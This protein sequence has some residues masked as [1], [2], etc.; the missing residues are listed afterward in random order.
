MSSGFEDKQWDAIVIGTGVGGGTVGRALAEKGLSVLF[1]EKGGKGLRT[2]QTALNAE[3]TDRVARQVRGFWPDPIEGRINGRV[4]R[5]F[6][7]LGAGVGGSSVYYAATLERPEPHDLD[8]SP[9]HPHPAGGWPVQYAQFHPYIEAAERMYHICGS[10]DPLSSVQADNL[11]PAPDLPPGDAALMAQMQRVGLHPYRLHS[12]VRYLDG[13]LECLGVKCPR[14]CKM[15]GRSAGVEPALATGRATLLE[16]CEVIALRGEPG[17][18]TH[19]EALHDGQP[20][21]LRG[22]IVVLAAGGFSSPQL[23]LSSVAEH[24]PQ[25]CANDSGLVGRNLMFHINEMFALWP[26][27]SARNFAPSR[28]IGF[29]DLYFT[30]GT[31]FG[32]VQAMGL[33]ASYG[34]ILHHI[35]TIMDRSGLARIRPLREFARLPAM[36]AARILGDAKIF[37]GL[38]EDLGYPENRILPP[39]GSGVL[40][41]E[42]AF[43]EELLA[44]RKAFRKAI[45]RAFHGQRKMFLSFQPELN[46]GHPCGTL[47]FGNAPE[48][49]VLNADC[50]AHGVRNLYVTDSSFM[51]SS[52]G[53]NPSLTIAANALRV[54]DRIAEARH[55]E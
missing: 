8:D 20:I 29:R 49:S 50:R 9:E 40:R 4:H 26:D 27:R 33:N 15:D 18:I 30:E 19:I 44:R 12:A 54:A 46:F 37:V 5:F 47:R 53:V 39:D 3:L 24:W 55:A 32:M 11:R 22:H 35:R 28:A 34:D 13:C 17:R 31:R 14:S 7:P 16:R 45:R 38:M 36:V 42:Y 25:G 2:E 21:T 48:T 52:M 23:L 6:P 51:P 41:F 43:G 1:V 10:P